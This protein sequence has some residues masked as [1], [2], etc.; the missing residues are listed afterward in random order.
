MSLA[1]FK[2]NSFGIARSKVFLAISLESDP[3]AFIALELSAFGMWHMIAKIIS[4]KHR[5]SIA[6]ILSRPRSFS[7]RLTFEPTHP[8]LCRPWI[9]QNSK[10]QTTKNSDLLCWIRDLPA[11][12]YFEIPLL[13]GAYHLTTRGNKVKLLFPLLLPSCLFTPSIEKSHGHFFYCQYPRF[14]M[15]RVHIFW[16]FS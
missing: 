9:F 7:I 13:P 8:S 5:I 14:K 15:P 10:T 6:S 4:E 11:R 1:Y 16:T 3:K 12:S 2:Y